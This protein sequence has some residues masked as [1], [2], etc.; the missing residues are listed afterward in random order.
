MNTKTSV[1]AFNNLFGIAGGWSSYF[2]AVA[3]LGVL[4]MAI[5]QTLKDITPIRRWY[6]AFQMRKWLVMHAKLADFN[7]HLDPD[8]LRAAKAEEQIIVLATD[9]DHRSFYDLEADKL[10]GQLNAAVQLVLDYPHL[11]PE[12]LEC[13][14]ARTTASDFEKLM[15]RDVPDPLPP[16]AEAQ[17]S[18]KEQKERFDRRQSFSDARKRVT[19]Q[20]Q[21]AIDAFQINTSF[22]WKWMLQIASFLLTFSFAVIAV[23]LTKT[24]PKTDPPAPEAVVSVWVTFANAAMAGFLAPVARDLF[25]AIQKLREP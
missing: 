23:R 11:Y 17:L 3:G 12:C 15:R 4:T 14:A 5:I 21:R 10:C 1:D 24:V 20:I 19:H 6:Q 13:I 8:P 16:D 9:G 22:R 7:L 18:L 2:L 25:A